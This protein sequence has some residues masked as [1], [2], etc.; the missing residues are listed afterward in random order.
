MI[1]RFF[2]NIIT[3]IKNFFTFKDLAVDVKINYDKV[4]Q[5]DFLE[6]ILNRCDC[7]PGKNIARCV[8]VNQAERLVHDLKSIGVSSEVMDQNYVP[9][10]LDVRRLYFLHNWYRN[11]KPFS[12][13]KVGGWG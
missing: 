12:K 13:P 11:E 2:S 6:W 1:I 10:R 5:A 8:S 3:D 9:E 4:V 7:Y